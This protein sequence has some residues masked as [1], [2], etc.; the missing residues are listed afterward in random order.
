MAMAHYSTQCTLCRDSS[1]RSAG[2]WR[3]NEGNG[4]YF[5]VEMYSCQNEACE[6]NVSRIKAERQLRMQSEQSLRL[7]INKHRYR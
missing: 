7:N 3:L 6:L 4:K 2:E 5:C 1:K